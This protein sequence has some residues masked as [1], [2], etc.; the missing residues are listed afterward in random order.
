MR[1]ISGG[2]GLASQND[3]RAQFGLG[4]A[5]NA[6]VVRVEWPS[7]ITQ[8]FT[9]VVARQF[10]TVKE[11]SRLK[12]EMPSAGSSPRLTLTGGQGLAYQL[13]ISNDLSTWTPVATGTNQTGALLWTNLPPAQSSSVTFRAKEL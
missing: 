6:Q 3:L 8:E 2:G 11:P 9:N 10:L 7:G 12:A 4:D 1:E 5:T 13:E